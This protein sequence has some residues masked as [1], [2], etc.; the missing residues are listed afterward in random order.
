MGGFFLIGGACGFLGVLL[1]GW[2]TWRMLADPNRTGIVAM[3]FT[4]ALVV[5]GLGIMVA[6]RPTGRPIVY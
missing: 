5:L 3:A 2:V 4:G 1:G 6:M